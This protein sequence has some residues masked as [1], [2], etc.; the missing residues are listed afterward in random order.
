MGTTWHNKC[1]HFIKQIIFHYIF[2]S[3]VVGNKAGAGSWSE[4]GAVKYQELIT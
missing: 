2:F 1:R 4:L 3:T